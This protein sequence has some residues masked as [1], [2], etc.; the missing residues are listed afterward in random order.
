MVGGVAAVLQAAPVTTFDL[1][2]VHSRG[3]ENLERLLG[4]LNDVDAHYRHKPQVTPT[5]GHLASAGHQLLRTSFGSLDV[6]GTIGRGET[7]EDLL[8]HSHDV[9]LERGLS[10]RVLDLDKLIEIKEELGGDKDRA[11]LPVLRRTLEERQRK[12]RRSP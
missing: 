1:D 6:L 2:I 3:Q 9:D 11:V 7:F 5:I 4:A 8:K 10:V 12:R